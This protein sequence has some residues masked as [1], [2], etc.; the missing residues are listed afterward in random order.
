MLYFIQGGSSESTD[1][2]P[3]KSNGGKRARVVRSAAAHNDACPMRQASQGCT[4]PKHGVVAHM[5]SQDSVVERNQFKCVGLTQAVLCRE[6]HPDAALLEGAQRGGAASALG[7]AIA[8][9][10][11]YR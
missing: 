7:V 1:F 2:H 6:W 4:E 3:L 9:L 8:C 10:Q 11:V 5:T